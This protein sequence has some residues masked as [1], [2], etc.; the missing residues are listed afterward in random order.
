MN[1]FINAIEGLRNLYRPYDP[2]TSKEAATFIVKQLTDLQDE[3][4]EYAKNVALLGF[5]DEDMN[6][7]FNCTGSTYRSRRAELTRQGW[8]VPTQQRKR[9]SSGRR[10]VVWIYKEYGDRHDV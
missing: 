4:L 10:A 9:L 5:T 8:I 1:A 7:H 6:R 3:V 2:S